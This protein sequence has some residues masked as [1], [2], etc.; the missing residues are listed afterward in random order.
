MC[1]QLTCTYAELS[2]LFSKLLRSLL[3]LVTE[4]S[5]KSFVFSQSQTSDHSY[6]ARHNA[7]AALRKSPSP[8]IIASSTK[9][10]ASEQGTKPLYNGRS[11]RLSG[12]PISLYNPVFAQLKHDLDHLDATDPPQAKF[13]ERVVE[14]FDTSCETFPGEAERQKATFPI[15]EKLLD[16]AIDE[17]RSTSGPGTYHPDGASSAVLGVSGIIKGDTVPCVLFETKNELGQHGASDIQLGM[18]YKKQIVQTEVS[19]PFTAR[20][21]YLSVV[22][23]STSESANTHVSPPSLSP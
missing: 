7:L 22:F 12:M 4:V 8:S 10:F 6:I 17:K 11:A 15:L 5:R 2:P 23:T 3:I 18:Y 1:V 14:L 9:E 19:I 13:L 21:L 20:K 16:V